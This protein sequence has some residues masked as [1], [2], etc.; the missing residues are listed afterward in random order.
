[1]CESSF[2]PGMV[3][4]IPDNG[5]IP[6]GKGPTPVDLR[7]TAS[8]GVYK[9]TVK[10]CR[11]DD[12]SDNDT[13]DITLVVGMNGQLNIDLVHDGG[14]KLFENQPFTIHVS[15]ADS[16]E[17]VPY[18]TVTYQKYDESE[19]YETGITDN[20]GNVEFTSIGVSTSEDVAF[21]KVNVE[22]T[23]YD[24][25]DLYF[26]VWDSIGQIHGFVYDS[27][28][29]EGIGNALVTAEPGSYSAY[30]M[31]QGASKGRYV[32]RVPAGT[33]T[34][35][36]SK[37]GYPSETVE[38]VSVGPDG[39]F[40]LC[41]NLTPY[42]LPPVAEAG[43]RYSG[44]V[45]EPIT[46][47]G[48]GSYDPDG[49]I[50]QYDWKWETMGDW[51]ND[52]GP[53]LTHIYTTPGYRTISLRVHDNGGSTAEDT[54]IVTVNKVLKINAPNSVN[55]NEW[56]TVTVTKRDGS[57]I[58]GCFV[59]FNGE[60]KYAIF[61]TTSFQAPAVYMNVDKLIHAWQ[62]LSDSEAFRYITVINTN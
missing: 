3:T 55:E 51:E 13:V 28:T 7:V 24:S 54:A 14:D 48:S 43:G 4:F 9:G 19:M 32:L 21:C 15:D 41:F 42:N 49:Y 23:G 45:D 22:A 39:Y 27:V 25:T 60:T 33:Y 2:A 20:N 59:D 50:A 5:V 37:D 34:V 16:A 57:S 26:L 18:A 38:N 46:F 8:D 56:F 1:V 62:E 10:V 6:K 17:D 12:P 31:P 61:G 40:F 30:T 29:E 58:V 52:I 53:N 36:A 44:Y 11:V 35:T 47:D